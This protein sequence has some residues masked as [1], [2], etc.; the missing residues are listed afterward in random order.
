MGSAALTFRH[1][2]LLIVVAVSCLPAFVAA[3]LYLDKLPPGDL[4]VSDLAVPGRVAGALSLPVE[5]HNG[6][7]SPLREGEDAAGR[8]LN[9]PDGESVL[10]VAASPGSS[11]SLRFEVDGA[12]GDAVVLEAGDDEAPDG[13]GEG[14][15]AEAIRAL[16][17]IIVGAEVERIEMVRLAG[18]RAP[19]VTFLTGAPPSVAGP[20]VA[21][22][23]LAGGIAQPPIQTRLNWATEGWAVGNGS[24]V[25]GPFYADNIQALV[26][27]HTVTSNAYTQEQVP[28]LL[29]AIYYSHVHING[30]CDIGYNFVVDRFGTIWEGRTGGID[31]PVIGGHAKG[32]NTSTVGVALLGQHH[33]GANPSAVRPSSS[34]DDAVAQLGAW[35]LRQHGVDP[36]GT[37][38]LK[39]RSTRG[40]HRKAPNSWHLVSTILGHRDL[41]LT[42]CPGDFG[43]GT[44]AELSPKLVPL[45]ASDPPYDHEA[46]TPL[47]HGPGFVIVDRSGGVRPAGGAALPGIGAASTTSDLLPLPSPAPVAVGARRLDGANVS[48]YRLHGDGVLSPFGGAPG[49][50]ERPAGDRE[51][52]DLVVAS[53]GGWVISS[54][55]SVHGFGGQSDLTV[56]PGSQP[57]VGGDIDP[58]TRSGYLLAA[59]ATL[60]AVGGAPTRNV[61]ANGAPVID[62]AL[63]PSGDSGWVLSAD[64]KLLPFGSAAPA[65]LSSGPTGEAPGS[66]TA[67]VS[68]A[69]GDGGWVLTGDGQLWPFGKE[70]LVLPLSAGPPSRSALDVATVD[71]HAAESFLASDSAR[72]S[73]AL[74]RLFLDREPTPV[75]LSYWDG[76]LSFH[77]GRAAATDALSQ[78][79]EWAGSRIDAMYR[80][81]LKRP[82][83]SGGRAYW[84]AEM[85]NGLQLQ[86]LGV[87]FY[88][89]SEY[90]AAAGGAEPYVRQ[91]YRVLLNREA[92]AGG[93][94]FWVGQLESGQAAPT[95]IAAGFY[96]SPESRRGRV[97]QLYMTILGRVPDNAGLAFWEDQLLTIDD[98]RLAATLANS[99]E[100]YQRAVA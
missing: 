75:E 58:T 63:Q 24:C 5:L 84:L 80:D 42:S 39:N 81:V 95:S 28:A 7:A 17:P 67:I 49:V 85:R 15:G 56:A 19:K 71:W 16:G 32:F 98:V 100:F 97:V 29:R 46:W 50:A 91:L 93:L 35:K 10:I 59:D 74:I 64:G 45:L 11:Y 34:A 36:E 8:R 27:H 25:G 44:V 51:V 47:S 99:D 40:P 53:E 22:R 62:I 30:W 48:G 77:G 57:I 38:W 83:D 18:D 54:S 87:L 94:A 73:K 79:D 55:G 4:R 52:V 90:F 65:E 9:P 69:S 6:Y 88:G 68:S 76:R 20:S 92:D 26:V 86:Q 96:A 43:M 82:A 23:Q 3:S 78:S 1:R 66:F 37:T 60:R 13:G 61:S 41:G 14:G 89:S 72:Y 12:W 2:L 21:G 70:R 33:P 31:K